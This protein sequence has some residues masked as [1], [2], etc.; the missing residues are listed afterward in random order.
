MNTPP[1][2]DHINIR[3][4][5][6]VL[7]VLAHL[8]YQPWFALAEFVDNS[9]QSFV[10][11][12]EA[13][14]KA[15][16]KETKLRVKIDI[17]TAD[18]GCIVIRDNAAGISASDFP[19][20]FR[21]AALP[22]DRTGLGEFGMGM[23]SA[24]CWFSRRWSVRTVAVGEGVE[25]TV[26]FDI[27]QIVRDSLDELEVKSEPCSKANHFTE[28][29]LS[30]LHRV[31]IGRTLSKIRSHLTDIYRIFVRDG[32]LELRLN[33]EPLCYQH[34]DILFA[35]HYREPNGSAK[36]WMQAFDFNFGN[37]L[38]AHGFAAIRQKASVSDA[39]FALFRRNRLIQGSGDEGYRPEYIFGKPNTFP[40]QRV[41]GEIHLEGFDVSHTKDGFQWDENEQPFLELLREQLS[42]SEMPLLQQAREHRVERSRGDF[43]QGA[44]QA[45]RRTSKAISDYVPPVL[46]QLNRVEEEPTPNA[47]LQ[48]ADLAA[49]RV[50]DVDMFG[51]P[52][53]IVLEL[54]VDPAI[55]DWLEIS[56]E[57]ARDEVANATG[58][59]VVGLRLSLVHP[60]MQ[61]FCGT[62][63]DE[64][65][66]LLRVAA[67][68]GLAE[69]A[70][71][72]AGA[73]KAG[74][75]RRNVNELLRSALNQI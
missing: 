73:R 45:S 56:D 26:S 18:G 34:P 9:I 6:S 47:A 7:S 19:R 44:E 31:P 4:G 27:D 74:L 10:T 71:R 28:I 49:R 68:L 72:Q 65:E 55:G 54:S 32:V 64:I 30:D 60:F 39:G 57:V 21:P 24:A 62:T 22:P 36:A 42:T 67:A 12:R 66:P 70:A 46:S 15:D 25:R 50:I 43:T 61:R 40:Y 3:P 13:L 2:I 20:A 75:I 58:R 5:V 11:N 41:F 59:R 69:V 1:A 53:R 35:P 23:K 48:P 8:N 38:R 37:G 52:W 29:I 33:G 17:N 14:G 16:N 63:A 51:K